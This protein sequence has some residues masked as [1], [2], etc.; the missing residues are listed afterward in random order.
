MFWAFI[1]KLKKDFI[2]YY[3]N[4]KRYIRIKMNL[5]FFKFIS[6]PRKVYPSIFKVQ[7]NLNIFYPSERKASLN[8]YH[9]S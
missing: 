5:F 3:F 6:H 1:I 2:L 8:Q 4:T 9:H 7:Y